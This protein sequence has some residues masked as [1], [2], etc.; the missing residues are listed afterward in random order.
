MKTDCLV[1]LF[2]AKSS[3][4][5]EKTTPWNHQ[6]EW[7]QSTATFSRKVTD[8][9]QKYLRLTLRQKRRNVCEILSNTQSHHFYF[10]IF[11]CIFDYKIKQMYVLPTVAPS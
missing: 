8:V 9:G 1:L 3:A 5:F 11:I 10:S 7:T 6:T 2:T 4:L